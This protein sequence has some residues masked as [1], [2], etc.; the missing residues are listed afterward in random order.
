MVSGVRRAANPP[1][2]GATGT[3]EGLGYSGSSWAPLSSVR[4]ASG[5]SSR[6]TADTGVRHFHAEQRER[7]MTIPGRYC[8]GHYS[9]RADHQSPGVLDSGIKNSPALNESGTGESQ[10]NLATQAEALDQPTVTLDVGT[11]ELRNHTRSTH[12]GYRTRAGVR[13]RSIQLL[14]IGGSHAFHD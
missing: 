13:A 3:V 12:L 9:L 5:Q 2:Y 8:D 4:S 7:L 14:A 1:V 6:C 11:L 10:S